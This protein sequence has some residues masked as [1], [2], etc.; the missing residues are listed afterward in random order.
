M[1]EVHQ[2]VEV[3]LSAEQIDAAAMAAVS[4]IRSTLGN[5]F[6]PTEADAA[7]AA[8][9]GIDLDGGLID[10]FHARGTGGLWVLGLADL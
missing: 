10:E 2:G 1:A 9:A 5:V 3:P 6:F 7:V 4:A 8:V